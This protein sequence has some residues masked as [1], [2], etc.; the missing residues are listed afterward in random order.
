[1][2]MGV[3]GAA[4]AIA[5]GLGGIVGTLAVDFSRWLL[6]SVSLAYAIVFAAQAVLFAAAAWLARGLEG[7][8]AAAAGARNPPINGIHTA[9]EL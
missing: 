6:D 9:H 2:R 3:W 1:M 7:R 8:R 5:F 4:Q